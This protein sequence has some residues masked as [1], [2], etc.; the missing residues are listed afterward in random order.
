[1]NR[2]GAALFGLL[3]ALPVL[4]ALH[5]ARGVAPLFSL[6]GLAALA[7]HLWPQRQRLRL[8]APYLWLMTGLCLWALASA[9][10]A[11]D[12]VANGF[13]ALRLGLLMLAGLLLVSLAGGMT[14]D[15]SRLFCRTFVVAYAAIA[16]LIAFDL[17]SGMPVTRAS[18]ALRGMFP[19]DDFDFSH[20]TKNRAVLLALLL[21]P[22][23]LAARREW[24]L[25]TSLPLACL[26]LLLILLHHSETSLLC[27]IG[28]AAAAPL[29]FWRPKPLLWA[30]LLGLGLLFALPPL[31][32]GNMLTAREI[33]RQF[34]D[35]S[36]SLLARF[37]IWEYAA[38]RIREKPLA[39]LGFDAAR[40]IGG[41]E[42]MRHYDF[43]PFPD[44]ATYRPLMEPIPLHTHN[45]VIQLWLELGAVGAVL[46]GLLLALAW[47]GGLRKAD[48]WQRAGSAA[49]FMAAMAPML[50]SYGLF[51]NWWVG[52]VW[53][54]IAALQA[55]D[56]A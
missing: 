50:S 28:M 32:H 14:A 45:G 5:M 36:K 29:A 41:R 49:L 8:E 18:Y 25:K 54:A 47:R 52:S 35:T 24:G 27:V 31:L 4:I 55:Q 7:L 6:L 19:Q 1:M 11:F 3:S 9:L 21:P 33:A 17:A 53:I 43:D 39:G 12:P 42:P 40:E 34:P 48:P 2:W 37:I 51:Q 38:E 16:L 23:F 46:G 15:Q 26:A 56:A 20:D 30:G 10:W 44:G 22:A 13:G